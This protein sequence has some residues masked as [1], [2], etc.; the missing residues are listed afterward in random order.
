[1]SDRASSNVKIVRFTMWLYNHA[2]FKNNEILNL[3]LGYRKGAI[4]ILLKHLESTLWFPDL[5]N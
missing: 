2:T 5:G 3:N 4:V 1:M